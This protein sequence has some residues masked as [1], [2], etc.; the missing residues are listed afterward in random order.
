MRGSCF[1]QKLPF[2][3]G[4]HSFKFNI[5]ECGTPKKEAIG[6]LNSVTEYLYSHSSQDDK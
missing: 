3:Q 2:L 5:Y 4:F 1:L 6:Q